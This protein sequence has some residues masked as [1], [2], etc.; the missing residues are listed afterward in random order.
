MKK[1][2]IVMLVA[3]PLALL[4]FASCKKTI[5]SQ[6]NSIV[7]STKQVMS[8]THLSAKILP[9]EDLTVLQSPYVSVYGQIDLST[10]VYQTKD[11]N[12]VKVSVTIVP[13]PVLIK[14][15]VVM[16]NYENPLKT[17]IS[18]YLLIS[19][20][21]ITNNQ[22]PNGYI[23]YI[24]LDGGQYLEALI[25]NGVKKPST[26]NTLKDTNGNPVIVDAKQLSHWGCVS[27]CCNSTFNGMGWGEW[28]I[29]AAA[30]PECCAGTFL[31]CEINCTVN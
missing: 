9:G 7:S 10:T 5:V 31:A 1:F 8:Q 25:V 11:N 30:F 20:V 29:C 21:P 14:K 26:I 17:I 3:L 13:D 24:A 6:D 22:N 18:R 12:K 2:I 4:I 19:N 16:Y 28:I 27:G 23:R 15:F